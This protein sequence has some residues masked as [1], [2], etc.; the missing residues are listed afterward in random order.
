M[1]SYLCEWNPAE[2]CNL[3]ISY[4]DDN[5]TFTSAGTYRY[6]ST[7]NGTLKVYTL[8]NDYGSHRYWK[9]LRELDTNSRGAVANTVQFF[10][11]S[12]NQATNTNG[13]IHTA[14]GDT[15]YYINGQGQQVSIDA[16]DFDFSSLDEGVYTFG[17][18]TAKD[19]SDLSQDYTKQFRITKSPYGGTT[20]LYLMPDTVKTLYWW[21][22]DSG[23]LEDMT[24]ANGWTAPSGY[25]FDVPTHNTNNIY[26]DNSSSGSKIKGVSSKTKH[27]LSKVIAIVEGK[28]KYAQTDCGEVQCRNSKTYSDC[29]YLGITTKDVIDK[30][31]IAA[32]NV[33]QYM[34]SLASGGSRASILYALWY[35]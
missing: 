12:S 1:F 35:E 28:T 26:C 19:P 7:D 14:N 24:T 33:G 20:E 31:E 5:S 18:T 4:S 9:I 21:G 29:T 13:I 11:R 23:E 16:S 27:T 10:G 34:A 25:S 2:G 8:D 6:E 22:Y 3:E 30:L 15:V 32:S 17:S